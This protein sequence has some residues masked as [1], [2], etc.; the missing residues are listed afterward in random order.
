MGIITRFYD[1]NKAHRLAVAE[2]DNPKALN[3]L[4]DDMVLA[5]S[6]FLV[7]VQDDDSVVAVLFCGNDKAF[8]A[9]GDIKGLYYAISEQKSADDFFRHEYHLN[10]LMHTYPKP[11][12]A[13]GSG[14][15]MGGGMGLFV[16]CSHRIVTPS[17]VMA[18][19]EVSIGLFPDAGGSYFLNRLGKVGLF[20]GLTGAR[21]NATDAW[22]YQLAEAVMPNDGL[23][24]L[25]QALIRGEYS[26][27]IQDNHF[28]INQ[29]LQQLHDTQSLPPSNI[30]KNFDKI[31]HLMNAG[32]LLAVDNAICTSTD[33]DNF[34]QTAID[35]YKAGS[36]IT[37]ALTWAIYHK[38]GT[39]GIG[40]I[41]SLELAVAI[42]CC[43]KGEFVEGVRALLIDKD[44]S[45]NWQYE[46]NTL[47]KGYIE[48]FLLHNNRFCF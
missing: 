17:T 1:I 43:Q 11:L 46:L 32:D 10:H 12:I 44:K 9:G 19:P 15:V 29:I 7:Q 37:K 2:L 4:T 34:M 6:D 33:N 27:S 42:H 30:A 47:P 20:L 21:I 38:V 8:C 3:A 31:Q 36:A 48:Q 45:P 5:I 14:I 24:K 41:M 13:W 40:E 25:L 16:S 23:D 39:W 26:H 18:M 22:A 28:V 35:N